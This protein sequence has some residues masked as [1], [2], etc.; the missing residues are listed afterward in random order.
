M[1][2]GGKKKGLKKMSAHVGP[3]MTPMVDI[4]MCILIFF[5]LGS[6]FALPDLYL[7][8]NTPAI[9]Q[10]GLS[11]SNEDTKALPAVQNKLELRKIAGETKVFA[12][13]QMIEDLDKVLPAVLKEKQLTLSKDVQIII[14]P[15][16]AV[17]YQDVITV[18]EACMKAHF[19]NVAF[20]FPK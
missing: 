12:F 14:Q 16:K 10:K 5:M 2:S 19:G 1:S 17:K 7:T 3:N 6:S 4:V 9:A 8:N 13:G 18:Y 20:G 11:N 15:E